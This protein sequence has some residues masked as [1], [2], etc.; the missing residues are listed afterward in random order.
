MLREGGIWLCVEGGDQ[1]CVERG[2]KPCA[3]YLCMLGCWHMVSGTLSIY[4]LFKTFEEMV[5]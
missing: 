2:R 3:G 4:N 5:R 1:P